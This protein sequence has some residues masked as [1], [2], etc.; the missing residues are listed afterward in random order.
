MLITHRGRFRLTS[1]IK[2]NSRSHLGGCTTIQLDI[3][4]KLLAT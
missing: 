3:I 4:I 2:L 1:T